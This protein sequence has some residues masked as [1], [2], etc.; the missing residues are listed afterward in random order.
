MHSPRFSNCFFWAIFRLATKGGYLIIRKSH[1][2]I[3]LPHFLWS[4]NLKVFW[5]YSP[6]HPKTTIPWNFMLFRGFIKK[7]DDF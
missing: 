5:S 7:N 1:Y 3:F 4:R 2:G 6:I